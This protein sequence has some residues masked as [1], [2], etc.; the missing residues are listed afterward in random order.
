MCLSE[1]CEVWPSQCSNLGQGVYQLIAEARPTAA[2]VLLVLE[3]INQP[4]VMEEI[5]SAILA[6]LEALPS[7]D[8]EPIWVG[9]MLYN[10]RKYWWASTD[11]TILLEK[12]SAI[13]F[14]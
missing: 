14:L 1:A 5:K 10:D 8:Q 13:L 3:L 9:F 2:A 11:D 6:S 7:S 4:H 12:E